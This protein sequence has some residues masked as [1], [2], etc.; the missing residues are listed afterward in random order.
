MLTIATLAN[1]LLLFIRSLIPGEGANVQ[2][3]PTP[4]LTT[5]FEQAWV[6]LFTAVSQQAL[7]SFFTYTA[8]HSI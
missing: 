2:R 1:F 7:V 5:V 6:S 4:K 3:S 8:S